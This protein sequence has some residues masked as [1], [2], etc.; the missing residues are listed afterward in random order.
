MRAPTI[1]H[2][3]LAVA[4]TAG[5]PATP[6]AADA[7]APDP[8]RYS[9]V[10]GSTFEFGCYAPCLCPIFLGGGLRGTFMLEYGGFDG[11]YSNYRL[12]EVDWITDVGDTPV[13][14]RGEGTYR[15]GGEFA[16]VH[17]L[18]LDLEV[19]GGPSRRYDSGLVPGG[20]EFPR[21]DAATSLHGFFCFDS[22]FVVAAAPVPLDASAPAGRFGITRV[23]PNPFAGATVIEF[24]LPR[25]DHVG[26]EVFD[27]AGR[28]VRTL[29]A[30]GAR[31]AGTHR[32]NWDGRRDDGAAAG[33]G[34]Y[35]VR[36]ATG[37]SYD[38][39]AVVRR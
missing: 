21:I 8:V 30:A 24:A 9:L 35:F 20:Q 33:P 14:V 19:D 4:L 26:L 25:A 22:S 34:L 38:V 31:S 7:P 5:L 37:N 36:L 3:I 2:A 17:Q 6:A 16:L 11:L 39:H 29:E 12:T 28:R 10:T 32:T 18:T 15:I 1:R 23:T 13:K 27:A